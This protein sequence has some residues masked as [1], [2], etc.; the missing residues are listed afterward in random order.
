MTL[1]GQLP[2]GPASDDATPMEEEN[3][4]QSESVKRV[5][6]AH[7]WISETTTFL[8]TSFGPVVIACVP[9]GFF[10]FF[11]FFFFFA[12]CK[13]LHNACRLVVQFLR[14]PFF[15]HTHS[16]S[17]S[18]FLSPFAFVAKTLLQ[19][20]WLHFAFDSR[21]SGRDVMDLALLVGSDTAATSSIDVNKPAGMTILVP[22]RQA[23][24]IAHPKL[25]HADQRN[26]SGL[27]YSFVIKLQVWPRCC[28]F[29]R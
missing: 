16:L 24:F 3:S 17:P 18:F 23:A 2:S 10:F 25:A 21:C 27:L 6:T 22:A 12:V 14:S 8:E 9:G 1:I 28:G 19:V 13:A 15:S 26:R 7:P 20:Q 4:M 11:F 29:L 5:Q